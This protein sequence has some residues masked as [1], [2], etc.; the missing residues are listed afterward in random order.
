MA[1]PL[2]APVRPQAAALAELP[3]IGPR[4]AAR[5]ALSL[6][7]N[8]SGSAEALA[9]ALAE[10]GNIKTCERCFF[11]HQEDGKL[12]PICANNA[13]NQSIIMVVEKETDLI[14]IENTAK[15]PGRYLVLGPIPKIGMLSD[16]QKTRLETLKKFINGTLNGR[17]EEIILG[18]NPNSIGDFNAELIKKELSPL[19][20]KTSR[21]GRGLPMGGEIEFADDDTLG[22]ALDRRN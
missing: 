2:P 10:I 16:W 13:R 6:V 20:K 11:I 7:D 5:I 4:Q 15:F 12:C 22:A 8:P 14:S 9:K 17:A 21:L 18:F 19:A 1:P 3:S